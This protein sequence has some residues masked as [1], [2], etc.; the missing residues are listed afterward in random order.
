MYVNETSI[1][2]QIF[3]HF[4]W[5]RMV[6]NKSTSAINPLHASPQN[7]CPKYANCECLLHFPTTRNYN[8]KIFS[9]ACYSI[10]IKDYDKPAV[11]I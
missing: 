6:M 10:L 11:F 9:F 5:W 3:L 4:Y 1:V 2:S 8:L 7:V